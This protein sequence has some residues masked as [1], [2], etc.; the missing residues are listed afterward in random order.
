MRLIGILILFS[1]CF[2][3]EA[4][5]KCQ[6]MDPE[7]TSLQL[8]L[9]SQTVRAL[10]TTCRQK[11][12]SQCGTTSENPTTA[13]INQNSINLFASFFDQHG[14]WGTN[15]STGTTNSSVYSIAPK[16]QFVKDAFCASCSVSA[17]SCGEDI[18]P[19]SCD[20]ESS[21]LSG[22]RLGVTI[23]FTAIGTV[24]MAEAIRYVYHRKTRT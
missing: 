20:S 14:C 2:L 19:E 12:C 4:D 21:G 24:M 16:R 17:I 3:V 22:S 13:G 10:Q 8:V 5:S 6:H 23:A 7:F 9:F 11:Q 15:Y 1:L 18:A